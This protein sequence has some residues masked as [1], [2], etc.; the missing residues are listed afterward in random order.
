MKVVRQDRKAEQINPE[1]GSEPALL[2]FDPDLSMVIV[3]AGDRIIA[4]QKASPHDAIYHMHHGN[5][6]VRKTHH[7]R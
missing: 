5:F 2:I 3:L 7:P 6:V 4:Q 1:I